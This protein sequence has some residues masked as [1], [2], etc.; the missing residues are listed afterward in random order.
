[1]RV[2][3]LITEGAENYFNFIF[4]PQLHTVKSSTDLKL[5]QRYKAI[6]HSRTKE[7]LALRVSEINFIVDFYHRAHQ[8]LRDLQILENIQYV[9]LLIHRLWMT[10]VS[11]M[12]Q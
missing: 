1:M 8:P 9:F 4:L 11:D 5:H 10:D 7:F 2:C 12:N 6:V 3:N